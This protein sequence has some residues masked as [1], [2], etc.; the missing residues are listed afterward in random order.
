MPNK[1]EPAELPDLMPG[2]AAQLLHVSTKTLTRMADR[3]VVAAVTLPSGH[4]RYFRSSIDSLA[5]SGRTS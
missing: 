4:R 2:E 3:G 5:S 1:T